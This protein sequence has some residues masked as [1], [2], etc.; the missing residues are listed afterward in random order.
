VKA[1]LVILAVILAPTLVLWA[2]YGAVGLTVALWILFPV[3][4]WIVVIR[5]WIKEDL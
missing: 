1:L 4:F 2:L 5:N 3:G